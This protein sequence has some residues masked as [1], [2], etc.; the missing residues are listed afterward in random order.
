MQVNHLSTF[1]M[2]G[3][4]ICIAAFFI[5]FQLNT[6][7]GGGKESTGD[8]SQQEPTAMGESSNEPGSPAANVP[9]VIDGHVVETMDAGRYTYIL[10]QTATEKIWVAGPTT[11]IKIGDKVILPA[12]MFMKNFKSETLD[13]TFE[14]IYFVPSL[15]GQTTG[16]VDPNEMMR[17]SHEG[18]DVMSGQKDADNDGSGISTGGGT[19]VVPREDV[20]DFVKAP[21]GLTVAEVYSRKSELAGKIVKVRGVVVKFTP[22]I[23]R[24]N[25]LHLQD[26]TGLDGFHDLTVTTNATVNVGDLITIQGVLAADKDFGAGYRYEVIIEQGVLIAD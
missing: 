2:V 15:G 26:G 3:L 20:G 17:R 1:R 5:L 14:K 7:C 12:G 22:A 4:V 9:D 18:R 24:T 8:D 6:G 16:S 13:R 10:V 21:G 19:T 23:M 25:W 11:E